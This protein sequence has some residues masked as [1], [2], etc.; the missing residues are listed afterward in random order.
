MPEVNCLWRAGTVVNTTGASKCTTAPADE[1]SGGCT[2]ATSNFAT[3]V[4]DGVPDV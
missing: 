3:I 2:M 1:D 4:L